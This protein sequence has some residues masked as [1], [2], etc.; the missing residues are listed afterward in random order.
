M[1][2]SSLMWITP[3][4]QAEMQSR[5]PL[6]AGVLMNTVSNS[7]RRIAP[8]GQTSTRGVDAVLA[9]V[10]HHQPRGLRAVGVGAE[11]LDELDVPPVYIREAAS[12]VVA[13]A[14]QHRQALAEA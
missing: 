5:Q 13:V 6:H 4:G 11:L 2:R 10:G 3:K 9:D 12:V 14:A 7:V 1:P 8:V